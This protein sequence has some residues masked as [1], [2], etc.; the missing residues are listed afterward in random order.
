M[1]ITKCTKKS[2][3]I[4]SVS[5]SFLQSWS[6]GEFQSE[7]GHKVVRIQAKAGSTVIG[8]I[9][10]FI[11][12]IGLGLSYLY[13]PKYRPSAQP[14]LQDFAYEAKKQGFTCIRMEPSFPVDISYLKYT[15]RGVANSQPRYTLVLDLNKSED[16]IFEMMHQKTRYNIRLATKKGVVIK[17]EKNADIF[18][19]LNSQTMERDRFKGHTNKYYEQFI[20]QKNVEQFIA[21]YEGAPITSILCIGFGDTFT[22]VHGASSNEHRNIMAPYIM[23]WHAILHAK[24]QGFFH[25]DFWGIA[26]LSKTGSVCFNNLCWNKKHKLSGVTRFKV[27]FGGRQ[28]SYP[29]AFDIVLR[30][31]LYLFYKIVFHVIRILRNIKKI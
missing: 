24:K 7:V 12:I 14:V 23:Q 22:Y 16:E 28:E 17:K 19:R 30:P 8:Q 21:Y 31:T 4:D 2:Y 27:G 15:T 25:Y 29:Q 3:W 1:N 5:G 26:P 20:S 18:F 6:W 11:H 10:G 13:V 9:Q